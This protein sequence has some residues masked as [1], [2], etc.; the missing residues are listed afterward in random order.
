MKHFKI[1][2]QMHII[3]I[4]LLPFWYMTNYMKTFSF[5][6]PHF[7]ETMKVVANLFKKKLMVKKVF[8]EKTSVVGTHWN[9]LYV[10]IPM[11]TYKCY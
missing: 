9:C 10:A 8:I 5:L 2:C 6:H 4:L 1:C 11:S 7:T 3:D